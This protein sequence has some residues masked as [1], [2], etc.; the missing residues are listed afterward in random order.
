M[1]PVNGMAKPTM[2]NNPVQLELELTTLSNVLTGKNHPCPVITG[3]LDH[4]RLILGLDASLCRC[5]DCMARAYGGIWW[6][7]SWMR[8]QV[9]KRRHAYRFTIAAGDSLRDNAE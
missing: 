4:A 9:I 6:F 8:E 3:N 5:D 1:P 2:M 7:N